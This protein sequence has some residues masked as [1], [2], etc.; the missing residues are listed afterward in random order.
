[1]V[2]RRTAAGHGRPLPQ[3]GVRQGAVGQGRDRVQ[4]QEYRDALTRGDAARAGPQA[5]RA[6]PPVG[7]QAPVAKLVAAPPPAAAAPAGDALPPVLPPDVKKFYLPAQTG[8]ELSGPGAR[9]R[10]SGVRPRQTQ[11]AGAPLGDS[12][13]APPGRPVTRSRGT[14]R[15]PSERRSP[16]TLAAGTLG[17]RSRRT[18]Y[19]TQIEVAR[20]AFAEYLYST[21][22]LALLEN[23]TLELMSQPGETRKRSASAAD[24][25]PPREPGSA[26]AG[27][28]EVRAEV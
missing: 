19:R 16:R 26:G 13:L 23:R 4:D 1:M 10:G 11:R 12:L 18:R 21:Q 27:E 7:P 14:R 28:S 24:R 3:P 2:P 15:P 25:Q 8:G 22:K 9:F 5:R 20:K 6:V 17:R